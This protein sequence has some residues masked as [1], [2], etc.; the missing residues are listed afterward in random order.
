[1]SEVALAEKGKKLVASIQS[2]LGEGGADVAKFGASQVKATYS[3][4]KVASIADPKRAGIVIT[5]TMV[6][7]ALLTAGIATK[8]EARA[9]IAALGNL[10]ADFAM[11]GA[12]GATTFGVGAIV[13]LTLAA[14]DAYDVGTSCFMSEGGHV[15]H[16]M[17]QSARPVIKAVGKALPKQDPN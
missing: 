12:M 10:A 16:K 4:T 9:C 11:A 1:M 17:V 3:L 15:T 6:Q 13:P 7:K 2:S 5:A 14:I 8:E